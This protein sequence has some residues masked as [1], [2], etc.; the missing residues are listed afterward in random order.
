MSGNLSQ[1][2][3]LYCTYAV[4]SGSSKHHLDAHP[5]LRQIIG[6]AKIHGDVVF[7]GTRIVKPWHFPSDIQFSNMRV[8]LDKA[9]GYPSLICQARTGSGKTGVFGLDIL[10]RVDTVDPV[11]KDK[12][13]VCSHLTP[14]ITLFHVRELCDLFLQV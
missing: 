7:E 10:A 3:Y 1:S 9:R 5:N 14:L 13:Q 6:N 8:L 4:V 12:L 11:F 2:M